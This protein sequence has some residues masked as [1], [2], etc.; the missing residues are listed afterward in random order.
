MKLERSQRAASERSEVCEDT[1]VND[2]KRAVND[3]K[4]M[5][6]AAEMRE[7]ESGVAEA[8]GRQGHDQEETSSGKFQPQL[9]IK[10][11]NTQ[12]ALVWAAATRQ[13]KQRRSWQSV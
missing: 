1:A 11:L 10:E 2:L 13:R 6:A 12:R 5:P 3:P 8:S 7:D 4:R 9:F